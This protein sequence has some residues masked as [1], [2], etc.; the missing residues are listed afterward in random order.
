MQCLEKTV[1]LM[2]ERPGYGAE[3]GGCKVWGRLR[4]RYRK[5]LPETL[6]FAGYHQVKLRTLSPPVC[7]VATSQLLEKK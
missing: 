7:T 5:A 4:V 6:W 3:E 1:H 2:W